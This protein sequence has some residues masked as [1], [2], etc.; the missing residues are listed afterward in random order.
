MSR[1]VCPVCNGTLR[2]SAKGYSY[3]SVY[4]GYDEYTDTMPCNNCGA[5]YMYG[6]ATGEV[7]LRPDGTPCKHEYT[8]KTVGRC[9]TEYK[10]THCGDTYQIDSG[11]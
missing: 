3:K 6:T 9:L 7:R 4:S 1:G 10:C 11:D 2:M 8:S 5:Q